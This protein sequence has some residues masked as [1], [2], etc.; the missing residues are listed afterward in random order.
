MQMD[1]EVENYWLGM[2]GVVNVESK[3]AAKCRKG[4][5]TAGRT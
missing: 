2:L 3:G 4:D 5:G 1:P